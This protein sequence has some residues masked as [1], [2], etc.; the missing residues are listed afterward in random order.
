MIWNAGT[1]SVM[2]GTN[3]DSVDSLASAESVML[4]GAMDT[5]KSTVARNIARKALEHGR[6]VAMVDA[7][8]ANST[9]GPPTCVGLSV[10]EHE[11]QLDHF[12]ATRLHFV[13]G[14]SPSRLVL[15]DV[16]ATA[17]MAEEG[18]RRA[19]MVIVDTTG[20][21]SGVVGETLKYHKVELIRP[22]RVVALQRG[23][24]MEPIVGMLNRFFSV[25]ITVLP[26][27]PEVVPLGPDQREE[28]RRKRF[29]EAFADPLERW[30][31]RPTVFA[32]TL[33]V[34][35]DLERLDGVLVGIQDGSGGCLGLG[36]LEHEEG[37]LRVVTGA[38]EGMKGLRLGSLRIDLSTYSVSTVNLRELIF[39]I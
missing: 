16:I 3:S 26:A 10:I 24:E 39:G 36:R 23:G 8:I 21:V 33:P 22:E 4:L 32:P 20:A 12:E 30:R 34:G 31:V 7:D 27:D 11:S 2:A 1:I 17:A 28:Q 18:R 25:D 35:L 37:A 29:A 38:G 19:D 14:V 13:G 9:I 6:T 5:G 15:Q